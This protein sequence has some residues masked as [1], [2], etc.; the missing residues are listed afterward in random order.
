MTQAPALVLY[1]NST[2][3]IWSKK[4]RSEEWAND[5]GFTSLIKKFCEAELIS[6]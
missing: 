1:A 3:L 6:N 2:Y 5:N 4:V